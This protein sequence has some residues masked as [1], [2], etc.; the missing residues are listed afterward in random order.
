MKPTGSYPWSEKRTTESSYPESYQSSSILQ[1]LS[2]WSILLLYCT[3]MWSLPSPLCYVTTHKQPLLFMSNTL[4]NIMKLSKNYAAVLP[5]QQFTLFGFYIKFVVVRVVCW[6]PGELWYLGCKLLINAKQKTAA[7]PL[8]CGLCVKPTT[9]CW[10]TYF[11]S[12]KKLG[13]RSSQGSKKLQTCRG[14]GCRH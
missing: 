5:L 13:S 10:T 1:P 12:N 4:Q 11:N 9:K 7:C 3:A 8:G 14:R 6:S 2:L